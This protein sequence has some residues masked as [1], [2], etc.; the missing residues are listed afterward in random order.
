[1]QNLWRRLTGV[2]HK[3]TCD[4]LRSRL[5]RALYERFYTRFSLIHDPA[6]HI[7]KTYNDRG[8]S[9]WITKDYY[10]QT[11][12]CTY[13]AK[14]KLVPRYTFGSTSPICMF[15]KN[16]GKSEQS[17]FSC[18]GLRSTSS[19]WRIAQPR[20]HSRVFARNFR[21]VCNFMQIKRLMHFH[22]LR[23]EV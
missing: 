23:F 7:T 4:D 18:M 3:L 13:A 9:C 2:Q 10:S 14:Y 15:A 19:L 22:N 16:D 8:T 21:Q 1:M 20:A 5:I 11:A 12:Y 6:T 17:S